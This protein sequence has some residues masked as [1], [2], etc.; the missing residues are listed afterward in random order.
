M[1][2]KLKEIFE[3]INCTPLFA[4]LTLKRDDDW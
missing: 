1:T 3:S 4:T 2:I